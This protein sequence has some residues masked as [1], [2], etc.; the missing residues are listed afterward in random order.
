MAVPRAQLKVFAPLASFPSRERDHWTAYVA[1]GGGL[2]R[3]ELAAL[4]DA[5]ARRTGVA[6][7]IPRRTAVALVRRAGER[8]LVCPVDLDLRA[9]VAFATFRRSVPPA[10]VAAFLPSSSTR[11]G[12]ERLVRSAASPTSSTRGG[13]SP[14]HGSSRSLRR[15][16]G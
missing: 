4:E 2:T 9:A 6:G 13:S 3:R 11:V 5:A 8:V 7:Q 15:S 10:V 14:C 1:A 12:L 16:G